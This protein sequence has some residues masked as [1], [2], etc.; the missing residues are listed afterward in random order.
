MPL[1]APTSGTAPAAARA[2]LHPRAAL[3]GAAVRPRVLPVC[4][5]YAGSE[6]FLRKALDLQAATAVNGRARFD[7]TADC[8]DGAPLGGEADH[9]SLIGAI[10]AS[11]DN[12]CARL[13]VR[14]HDPASPHWRADLE[15]IVPA[16]G[17]ALAY[18]VVPKLRSAVELDE[19]AALIDTLA[20]SAELPLHALIETHAALRE[21]EAIAAHPRVECLSFGLM[22]FVSAHGGA[23]GPEALASPGQFDHPLVRRAKLE[24]AAAAHGWGKVPSHNVSTGLH[25][26]VRVRD[27]ARRAAQEFGYLRMWSVHPDQI[28]A[29]VAALT[30]SHAALERAAE[31]I[32]A[33]QAADWGPTREDGQLHDRASYRLFWQLLERAHAAGAPLP[34]S[35]HGYFSPG[36]S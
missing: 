26:A 33:A 31:V 27:D 6:R 11:A 2:V 22:D 24:I 1:V 17:G 32:A 18:V 36:R 19:V 12:R 10:A 16:A 9:A 8:E 28:E 21:V 30:P 4:D 25:D 5:H 34:A 20:P 29:I 15:R 3:Y 35:A 23:I 13:G 7:V 14:I